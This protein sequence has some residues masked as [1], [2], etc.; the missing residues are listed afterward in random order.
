MQVRQVDGRWVYEVVTTYP[1]V[2]DPRDQ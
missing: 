2:R 1:A